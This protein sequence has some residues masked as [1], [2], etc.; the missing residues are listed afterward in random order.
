[1]IKISGK[2]LI[3]KLVEKEKDLKNI[4]VNKKLDLEKDE[5]FPFLIEELKNSLEDMRNEPFN[6]ENS[7]LKYITAKGLYLPYIQAK[8][9][10]FS[11]TNLRNGFFYKGNFKN[12]NFSLADL[13]E[14]LFQEAN[15]DCAN[16]ENADLYYSNLAYVQNLK[17]ANLTGIRAFKTIGL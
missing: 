13:R 8:K 6:F 14:T 16:F 10:D 11:H 12:A 17:K 9:T 7:V 15:F 2:E 4:I 3:T 1:M 5:R